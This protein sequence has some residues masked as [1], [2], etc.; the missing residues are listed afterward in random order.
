[1]GGPTFSSSITT[2]DGN[3]D[4][5]VDFIFAPSDVLRVDLDYLERLIDMSAQLGDGVVS[6]AMQRG[7]IVNCR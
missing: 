1:M 3:V 4:M 2:L 7:I 5:A 6:I